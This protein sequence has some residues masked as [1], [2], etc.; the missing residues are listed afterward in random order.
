MS[1]CLAQFAGLPRAVA[2]PQS[3]AAKDSADRPRQPR[4]PA[5]PPKKVID[6]N[7]IY[8]IGQVVVTGARNEVERKN[9]PV[10]VQLI[11]AEQIQSTGIVNLGDILRE[12][13][14]ISTQNRVREGVQL[15]GLDPAYTQIL[16]DGQP[17]IGRVAGVLDLSRISMGNV[18]RIEVVKGPMSSLYGSDA[19]A[20]V[21]NI[22]TRQ[23]P[24]GLS[25]RLYG[26]T[27][28]RG[29]NEMQGELNYAGDAFDIAS[30][31]N[32]KEA[33]EFELSDGDLTVPYAG[34]RDMT[35][36]TRAR[37]YPQPNIKLTGNARLFASKSSGTFI[38]SFFNQIAENQGSVRQKEGSF[39]LNG[40]WTH[41]RARLSA[42]TYGSLYNEAIDFDVEQGAA[43][44]QD[45]LDR[46]TW[47]ST[48]QYDVL[49]NL[50]NR[51]TLGGEYQY[52]D[53]SGTR[54]TAAPLYRTWVAFGQWE[55]NPVDWASYALS[56]RY[57]NN[58]IYGDKVSP[59]FS[60]LFKPSDSW[61][62]RFSVGSGFR[63]PDFRQLSIAFS[64][65][66]AGA[67][68][69]L[70]GNP[71]LKPERSVAFDAGFDVYLGRA[72]ILGIFTGFWTLDVHAFRNNVRDLIDVQALSDANDE[73]LAVYSYRN[74]AR[75]RT[76]GIETT[77]ETVIPMAGDQ[78]LSAALGYQYLD[79]A[80]LEVLDAIDNGQ[81]GRADPATG[82]F[83][84]LTREEY[85]G[86]WFRSKHTGIGR[87]HYTN[88]DIGV[89]GSLRAQ[90]I[91]RFGDEALYSGNIGFPNR[92]LLDRDEFYAPAYW[93]INATVSKSITL[94]AATRGIAPAELRLTLGVTNL[95]DELNLQSVPDLVGRQAFVNL[96]LAWR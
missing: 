90:Y 27:M 80:D 48:A 37:W 5:V 16:V 41:G 84:P 82:D 77:L 93:L 47:R 74:I 81:A 66:L 50:R 54:Y 91:G 52:D 20:G 43:G 46:R 3:A 33:E 31:Y 14:G 67:G 23:P 35:L 79:A 73:G 18:E 8:K 40:S 32:I 42:T 19:L 75:V 36:Q 56:S 1:V 49:W 28:R 60:L 88:N 15:M 38:E 22:I 96:N 95:L 4:L 7:K 64:N 87:L 69:D 57:D 53:I 44:R 39:T 59:K 63:A 85:G 94:D 51:F 21:I 9:S 29:P 55:G 78:R 24:P 2:V 34:Y 65:R 13:T 30:Y 68:Y 10:R 92:K 6:S 86:L 71:D 26:Q 25:G 58:N 83:I 62:V 17:L 11:P 89:A 70:I 12:Q 61:R 76:Q 72:D 45:D